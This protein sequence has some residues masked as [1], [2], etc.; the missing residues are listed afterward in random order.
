MSFISESCR[1]R[2]PLFELVA[3]NPM[4]IVPRALLMVSFLLLVLRL[5]LVKVSPWYGELFTLRPIPLVS[6][7]LPPPV[8]E[9]RLLTSSKLVSS[10][11]IST[12][13]GAP[14]TAVGAL[15]IPRNICHLR[16][17]LRFTRS[18][19]RSLVVELA[20]AGRLCTPSCCE[21]VSLSLVSSNCR[22]SLKSWIKLEVSKLSG[23]GTQPFSTS[24][25]AADTLLVTHVL[26]SGTTGLY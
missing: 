12:G 3:G 1:A 18:S 23:A 16:S 2:F 7:P 14:L 8:V 26:G 20:E 4:P 9:G 25:V 11:S 6:L 13:P 19:S 5:I 24:A 22:V 17:F 10:A 21:S 15:S